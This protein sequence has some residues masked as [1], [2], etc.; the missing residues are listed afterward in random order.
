MTMYKKL[1]KVFFK[2][3]FDLKKMLGKNKK[4]SVG[5]A[6]LIAFLLIYMIGAF[7]GTFGYIFFNLGDIFNQ[8][9]AIDLL[10]V[11][12]FMYSTILTMMFVI[13]RANGYIFNYK[14]YEL[15][16]PLPIK[17]RTVLAAKLTVMLIFIYLST[18]V[19]LAPI[20]FSYFYHGGFNVFS[21][22]I[23]LIGFITI[24]LIPT[25]VFSFFSLL[26][27]Q[28]SSRFR[29]N[30]LINIVLLFVL[31]LGIMY[32]SFSFNSLSSVNPFLNQQDFMDSIS[33][34]YP[35]VKWFT[36]AVATKS[37]LDLFLLLVFNIGLFAGFI[38]FIQGLVRKTNQRGLTKL[39]RK[40]NKKAVSK[41]R[42]I[43]TSIAV[44]E[45][46]K[47]VNIP[48]Y[49]LNVGMGVVMLFVLA[50]ASLFF[51][52]DIGLFISEIGGLGFEIEAMVLIVIGFCMSMV[53]ST[54]ISLSLEGKNFWILK[55]LPIKP[56]TVMHGKMLFNILLALP[57]ALVAIVLLSYS[58]E[59]TLLKTVL[60]MLF[61]ISLS[62][63][64]TC[65]G[66]LIN[67]FVPKFDW[68]NPTQIVKQSAGALLGMFGSWFFLIANGF[69]YYFITKSMSFE[70]AVLLVSTFNLLLAISAFMLV[71]KMAESLFIKF[72][73]Y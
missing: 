48:I 1:L 73:V 25:I 46:K 63:L 45:A 52:E 42:S 49:A 28:I 22:I 65:F 11:Y 14:D 32:L 30:N 24:P 54:A 3:N 61:A 17:P 67:L 39:T 31:F 43:V 71:N 13:F 20:M 29:K 70:I 69:L 51:K 21:F 40:N 9:G 56:Q 53:Y 4:M 38:Y 55:S 36:E 35:P 26:I 5:K 66:S 2:E 68:R 7:V 50:I 60:M 37:I 12:A 10:L 15:L 57:V 34:Y 58:M 72:E 27:S 19:F 59:I 16:E 18:F 64:T 62:L 41:Q 6:I 8:M 44:K 33:K 23:F 47:F